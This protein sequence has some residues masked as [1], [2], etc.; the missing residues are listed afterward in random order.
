MRPLEKG[1]PAWQN[2][3]RSSAG[4]ATTG[5]IL[6]ALQA[7]A[8]GRLAYP[9]EQ[10]QTKVVHVGLQISDWLSFRNETG[11]CGE[12]QL[13][14]VSLCMP[15]VL[16]QLRKRQLNRS[17]VQVNQQLS[18]RV[19]LCGHHLTLADLVIYGALHRPVVSC[20][21]IET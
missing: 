7:P 15:E 9:A 1:G 18:S 17:G 12:E 5:L 4:K 14:K 2:F 3:K 21:S 13:T 8:S 6:P 16:W 11:C 10:A 19:F 20:M